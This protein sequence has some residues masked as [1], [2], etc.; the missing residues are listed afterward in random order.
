LLQQIAFLAPP[1]VES[2]RRGHPDYDTLEQYIQC[3]A[4]K[5]RKTFAYFDEWVRERGLVPV[6]AE[7][8]GSG[9]RG[10]VPLQVTVD[11]N[12]E[13]ERFFRVHYAPADL[14]ER[15]AERLRE[16]LTKAPDL[17]VYMLVSPDASCSECQAEILQGELLFMERGQPLCLACADLDHL[18]FLP[19]GD[20]AVT[21]RARKYSSL[22]AVVFRFSRARNHYERQGLLVTREAIARAEEECA[23]DAD[24]RATRRARDAERRQAED[25][26]LVDAMTQAILQRY[27]GCPA[28]E[29]R[30]IAAHTAS[31]GSGRVGRSAA[32]RAL[33]EQALDLA[34]RASI[35]HRHTN[36][37]TLLMQGMERLDARGMIRADIDRLLSEWL[38]PE[39]R[40]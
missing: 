8:R 37:D 3:G 26:D 32:G 40:E 14:S 15:K 22:S 10:A 7:Y 31:R 13:R 4:E 29:A 17:V 16:K 36:Y 1:H 24:V 9:T 19:A 11:G 30:E 23:A 25:R 6:E 34:V 39:D 2:W 38:M 21:R 28:D 18:E 27:P 35:R 12:P 5:Y 33:D 20:A